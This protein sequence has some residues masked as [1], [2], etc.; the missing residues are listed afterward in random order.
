MSQLLC[1]VGTLQIDACAA[2]AGQTAPSLIMLVPYRPLAYLSR[3]FAKRLVSL[4]RETGFSRREIAAN[5]PRL[6]VGA[7]PPH[8]NACK[9]P[10]LGPLFGRRS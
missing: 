9:I 3:K 10:D 7:G 6:V 1:F 4:G 2:V 8:E 5:H